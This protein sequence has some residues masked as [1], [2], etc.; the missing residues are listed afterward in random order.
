MRLHKEQVNNIKFLI[1]LMCFFCCHGRSQAPDA[2]AAK[3]QLDLSRW[4]FNLHPIVT[5]KGEWEAEQL[6]QQGKPTF[7]SPSIFE[8]PSQWNDKRYGGLFPTNGL[9]AYRLRLTLPETKRVLSLNIPLI[10]CAYELYLNGRLFASRGRV[11]FDPENEEF[12]AKGYY[13]VL[14]TGIR[15]IEIVILHSVQN[16]RGGRIDTGPEIGTIEYIAN[17]SGERTMADFSIFGFVAVMMFYHIVLFALR[18]SE[19]STLFFSLACLVIIIRVLISANFA[20]LRIFPNAPFLLLLK[21][22]YLSMSLALVSGSLFFHSIFPNS[23]RKIWVWFFSSL[24]ILF[25]LPI[26]LLKP[27]IFTH[28]SLA[29]QASIGCL[30]LVVFGAVMHAGMRRT[31]GAKTFLAGIVILLAG[32]LNDTL[33]WNG[34]IQSVPLSGIAFCMFFFSQAVLISVRFSAAF[35]R[36]EELGENLVITNAAYGRFV[37]KTFLENLGYSNITEVKL[38]DQVQKEMTILFSD[39]RS[40][41]TLSENMTPQENFNFLNSYLKRMSPIIQDNNGFID[42]Y[43]GDAI[44]ALFPQAGEDGL[45]ASIGMLSELAIYNEHRAKQ[46]Y[47]AVDIGVGLHTGRLILGTIG[48]ADRMDGTVIS[49]SVNLA[50]RIEGLTKFYGASIVISEATFATLSDPTAYYYRVLDR[51]VVKGKSDSVAVFEIFNGLAQQK[52]DLRLRT[53]GNFERGIN[54][55]MLEEFREAETSFRL[56][57]LDDPSDTA[58]DIYLKRC[59]YYLEHGVPEAWQAITNLDHK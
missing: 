48:S 56:V 45:K 37:P 7:A 19:K 16:F 2:R 41:T 20:I 1:L 54:Y 57:L 35:R 24:A 27:G 6:T 51:V 25:A 4:D 59:L 46:G 15:K 3:G 53:K 42:K 44:M 21:L 38:G 30:F 22:D 31:Q 12:S 43:I 13:A 29:M 40:F 18:P 9:L 58:A 26:M 5:L 8:M 36:S 33:F 47:P 55:Y 49:D 39:I 10:Y 28:L 11:A 23:F 34:L 14:P 32:F 50:S 52:I 17:R